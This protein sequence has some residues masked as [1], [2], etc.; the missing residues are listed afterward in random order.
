M[1]WKTTLVC[2]ALAIAPAACDDDSSGDGE[3]HA[4]TEDDHGHDHGHDHDHEEEL[5]T[6]VTLTFTSEAGD[7]VTAEFSDPDGEAGNSGTADPIVLAPDTTYTLDIALYND[8]E[9]E[10]VTPEIEAEAEE[11]QF[12]IYGDAVTG[13]GSMGSGVVTHAYADVE[14]DYGENAVGDD[15]P[16]GLSNTITTTAAGG[17]E[18]KVML[19]HLP[20]TNDEPQKAAGLAEDFA[21]GGDPAGATDVDVTF[22]LTVE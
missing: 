20:E 19:R 17:G 10:D 1:N 14:S 9:D 15:L 21:N 8:L 16:V 13:P 18:F 22:A 12:I 6:T 11:H 7:T 2:S 4:D 5:I 3:E